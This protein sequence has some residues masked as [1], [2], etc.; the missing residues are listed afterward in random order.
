MNITMI[1]TMII[2]MILITI[3]NDMIVSWLSYYP[4]IIV[5]S[6]LQRKSSGFK[7]NIKSNLTT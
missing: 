5:F 2:L 4:L 1:L 6:V 3:F 7:A